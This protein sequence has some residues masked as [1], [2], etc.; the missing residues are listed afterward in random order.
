MSKVLFAREQKDKILEWLS[1]C[2][3][4]GL[5]L[6]E[7]IEN[8]EVERDASDLIQKLTDRNDESEAS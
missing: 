3:S 1:F 6:R 4:K 8:L 5:T 2:E 7:V